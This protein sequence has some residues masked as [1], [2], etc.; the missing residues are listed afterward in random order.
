MIMGDMGLGRRPFFVPALICFFAGCANT[1]YCSMSMEGKRYWIME[2]A[3]VPV[4]ELEKAKLLLYTLLIVPV[5]IFAGI[6]MS[7]AFKMNGLWTVISLLLPIIYA[8][9]L[10]LWS[11]YIGRRFADYSCEAESMAL[12]RGVPFIFGCILGI[13]IPIVLIILLV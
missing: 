11:S 9:A 7:R 5:I 13:V 1:C 12:H 3:P 2:A 4:R 10:A 8:A 6:A